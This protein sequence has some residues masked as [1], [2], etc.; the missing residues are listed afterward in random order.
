MPLMKKLMITLL[1]LSLCSACTRH[2]HPLNASKKAR[3]VNELISK[4]PRC[5]S[6]KNRLASPSVD[7]DGIDD[8]YHDA[9][10][11]LCI[12]RDV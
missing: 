2:Y 10:K 5:S 6:F 9:T 4:D 11:A 7:D 12:N 1:L 8:V 3:L